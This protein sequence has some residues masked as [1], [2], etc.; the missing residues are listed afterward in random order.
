MNVESTSVVVERESDDLIKTRT[1]TRT[2]YKTCLTSF[3]R[4]ILD[5]VY[6]SEVTSLRGCRRVE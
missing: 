5:S 3:T 2:F 4:K 1:K 6:H